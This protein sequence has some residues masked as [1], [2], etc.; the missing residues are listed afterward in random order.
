MLAREVFC[1]SSSPWFKISWMLTAVFPVSC[2]QL[3][4]GNNQLTGYTLVML[5]DFSAAHRLGHFVD[6]LRLPLYPMTADA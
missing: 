6:K 1:L 4:T 2:C 3:Q 5:T